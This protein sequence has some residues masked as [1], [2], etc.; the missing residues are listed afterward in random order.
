MTD[1]PGQATV[2]AAVGAVDA[3]RARPQR[4]LHITGHVTPRHA[5]PRHAAPRRATPQTRH[6]PYSVLSIFIIF[7][8][9]KFKNYYKIDIIL[10][11]FKYMKGYVNPKLR[12]LCNFHLKKK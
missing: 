4:E 5:T 7:S 2:G 10:L 1:L 9:Y 8:Y 3:G 11:S 6:A 12:K